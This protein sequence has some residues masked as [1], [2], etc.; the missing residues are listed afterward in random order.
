MRRVRGPSRSRSAAGTYPSGSRKNGHIPTFGA[1]VE[2]STEGPIAV[3]LPAG[4]R[5][6]RW[7][8]L[9]A[10]TRGLSRGARWGADLC[11]R[12]ACSEAAH[13]AGGCIGGESGRHSSAHHIRRSAGRTGVHGSIPWPRLV[14]RP[15][16]P[17]S[18]DGCRRRR[19][20]SVHRPVE[21]CRSFPAAGRLRSDVRRHNRTA[22]SHRPPPPA[23]ASGGCPGCRSCRGD[24]CP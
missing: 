15:A 4:P 19:P 12:R 24:R 23:D 13:R 8:G 3:K 11:I 9:G 6:E 2:A 17:G 5:V 7:G 10:D 1:S 21:K 16:C 18:R 14:A 20:G 22:A